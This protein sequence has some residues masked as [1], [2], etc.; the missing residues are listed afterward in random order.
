MTSQDVVEVEEEVSYSDAISIGTEGNE[1]LTDLDT[2]EV[3]EELKGDI[4]IVD[5]GRG[6]GDLSPEEAHDRNLSLD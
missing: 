5:T 3:E 6:P 4:I 2:T 1:T